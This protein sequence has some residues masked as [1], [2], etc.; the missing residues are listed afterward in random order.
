MDPPKIRQTLSDDVLIGKPWSRAR[1]WNREPLDDFYAEALEKYGTDDA[2]SEEQEKKLR[3]KIDYTILPVL[4]VCYA[5]YYIDKTTLSYAAIFGIKDDLHLEGTEYSWLSSIFYFGWLIWALPTNMLMLKSPPAKYLAINIFLWGALLMAQAGVTNF[6]GLAALRIL[7]GAA[8]AIADPAFMLITVSSYTRA[9]QPSRISTWY[10]ANGLGVAGGGMLGY[11]IGHIKGRLAS[12][13]YEFLIVGALC[14]AWGIVIYFVLP[15]SPVTSQWLTRE[16]RLM[17]V[18]RLRKNQTGI[19]NKQFKWYQA[20]EAFLKDPKTYLFFFLG[21]VGNIPNG[22]ISNFS[23]LILNGLGFDVLETSL[24][25]IP[26]GALVCIY[27]GLGAYLNDRL[28]KNSRT[29][30]CMLFML[31]TIGGTLG[32][33]LAP[34]NANVGRLICYYLTG[35]YQ[36]SFVLGVSLITSNVAGQTKKQIASAMIWLGACVGNIGGPFFYRSQDAPEYRLGIGSMLVCNCLEVLIFI[37]FRLY[38]IAENRRRDRLQAKTTAE[39]VA[40]N[41]ESKVAKTIAESKA[42]VEM[43]EEVD[44]ARGANVDIN[45]TAFADLTDFENLK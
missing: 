31:P 8:E 13:R 16:E 15:D 36:A 1:L 35:S 25:G 23:T 32:F 39:E 37:V 42:V 28:P 6:A 33:L 45:A 11:G 21:V 22:G 10:A 38:F 14:C 5:F 20:K 30:V 29:L 12:W 2:I 18:A 7:S 9:E 19:D 34:Q 40:E 4:A 43:T 26:Q 24:L 44:G 3:R 41:T 27:I 17:A